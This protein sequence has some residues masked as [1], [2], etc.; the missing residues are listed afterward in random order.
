[1]AYRDFTHDSAAFAPESGPDP[2]VAAGVELAL[3]KNWKG[4]IAAWSQPPTSSQGPNS[5]TEL[6]LSLVGLAQRVLGNWKNAGAT[7]MAAARSTIAQPQISWL[8]T[9]NMMALS[10]LYH[11]R[12]HFRLVPR[13][14]R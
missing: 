1:M 5:L 10:M 4:A 13:V 8:S 2:V 7:W 14:S 6:Q 9:G 12:D 11:Y 3:H